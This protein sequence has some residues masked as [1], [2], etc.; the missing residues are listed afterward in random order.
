MMCNRKIELEDFY[1]LFSK[2]KNV[3]LL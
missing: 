1:L 3:L 2:K